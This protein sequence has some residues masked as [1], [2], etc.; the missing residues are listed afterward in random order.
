[1]DFQKEQEVACPKCGKVHKIIVYERILAQSQPELKKKLLFSEL[2]KF[3]CEDCKTTMPLIYPCLYQDVEKGYMIWF[4]PASDGEIQ[5]K[6]A[7]F[8]V[9]SLLDDKYKKMNRQYKLRMVTSVNGMLEKILI[10]DEDMDDRTIEVQKVMLAAQV[11]ALDQYKEDS[12]RGIFFE[13]LPKRE[14]VYTILFDKAE[15]YSVKLDMEQYYRIYTRNKN[16]LIE[17]TPE[18]FSLIQSKWGIEQFNAIMHE[19]KKLNGKRQRKF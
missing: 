12:V 5:G 7:A 19:E 9:E 2:F 8:N 15:P 14:Y 4:A 13:V 3:E 6:I 18:G 11:Q 10:F 17:N 1:M 16:L